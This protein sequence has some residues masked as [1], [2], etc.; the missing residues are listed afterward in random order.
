M[1]ARPGI[2][3]GGILTGVA[4]PD[5][6]GGEILGANVPRTVTHRFAGQS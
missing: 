2:D 3:V 6:H 4:F 5:E 1:S